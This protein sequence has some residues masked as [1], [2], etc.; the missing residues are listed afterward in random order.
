M[1]GKSGRFYE[2][3]LTPDETVEILF[4]LAQEGLNITPMAKQKEAAREALEL[5]NVMGNALNQSLRHK[6]T[7][8][9]IIAMAIVALI[10]EFVAHYLREKFNH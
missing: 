5:K 6:P 7:S 9:V 4:D 10:T 1:D 3:N 8:V 2:D